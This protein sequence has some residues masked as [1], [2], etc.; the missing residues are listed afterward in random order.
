MRVQTLRQH[1]T[2]PWDCLED[3]SCVPL[4]VPPST[5]LAR[6][7]QPCGHPP[8]TWSI[9]ALPEVGQTTYQLPHSGA[10]CAHV[11]SAHPARK[12]QHLPRLSSSL[13]ALRSEWFIR[14]PFAARSGS[15]PP[16]ESATA[17]GHSKKDKNHAA[18]FHQPFT[19]RSS[20]PLPFGTLSPHAPSRL[21]R[22]LEA[23]LD[24]ELLLSPP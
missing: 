15:V 7:S 10:S 3:E 13:S 22:L 9:R 16:F 14:V 4:V 2:E 23:L 21:A 18:S 1:I 6:Q 8:S 17:C 12:R 24:E 19:H 11:S 5:Y 20:M